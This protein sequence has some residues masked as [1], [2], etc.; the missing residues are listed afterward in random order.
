VLAAAACVGLLTTAILVV[1][2]LRDIDTDRE[3]GKRTLA[4]MLGPRATCLEYSLVLFVAYLIPPLLWLAGW[5]SRWVM[6]PLLSF[7]W[8]LRL[9]LAVYRT[10]GSHE[11]S[12]GE[13]PLLNRTLARTASLDLAFSLLFSLGLVL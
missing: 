10:G 2:N 9:M 11:Q 12:E 1:N 3:I 5:A 6:L 7:P 4:V 13:G 8:A